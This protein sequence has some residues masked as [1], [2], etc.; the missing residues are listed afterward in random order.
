MC[1]SCRAKE[2]RPECTREDNCVAC[3]SWD[4]VI[5]DLYEKNIQR[6]QRAKQRKIEKTRTS[7]VSSEDSVSMH[8]VGEGDFDE[9]APG[10]TSPSQG[11]GDSSQAPLTSTVGYRCWGFAQKTAETGSQG[12][13]QSSRNWLYGAANPG[14]LW[15]GFISELDVSWPISDPAWVYWDSYRGYWEQSSRPV[16]F[17]SRFTAE[18]L[19]HGHTWRLPWGDESFRHPR[20][21]WE[22]GSYGYRQ[23][24]P[25]I[26]ETGRSLLRRVQA[27]QH[28]LGHSPWLL[29]Q[30]L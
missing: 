2:G 19:C 11:R 26:T 9:P 1:A 6:R 22:P 24:Q 12:G 30:R 8:T 25:F 4:D 5:W 20:Q 23:R 18:P 29:W 16:S 27:N 14:R 21:S 10:G 7:S 28:L 13:G 17:W 15:Y 3:V